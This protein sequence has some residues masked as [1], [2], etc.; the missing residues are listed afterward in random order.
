MNVNSSYITAVA[1][2]DSYNEVYARLIKGIGVKGDIL[3]G[4]STL[5]TQKILFGLF[6][7]AKN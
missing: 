2:D 5:V 4:F 1:N 7:N 6:K 3:V